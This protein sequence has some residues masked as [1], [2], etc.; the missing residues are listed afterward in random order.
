MI[1][2]YFPARRYPEV[3]GPGAET[4]EYTYKAMELGHHA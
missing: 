4:S 2:S 3:S 1:L